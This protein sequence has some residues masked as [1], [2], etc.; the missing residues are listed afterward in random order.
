MHNTDY[1]SFFF[2]IITDM[3]RMFFLLSQAG[4]G[5]QAKNGSGSG[6]GSQPKIVALTPALNKIFK[7]PSSSS[8]GSGSAL[9]ELELTKKECDSEPW[10]KVFFSSFPSF[11]SFFQL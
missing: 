1:M 5:S 4:M 7:E 2:L 8:S 3:D 10:E 11:L 9:L 6:S